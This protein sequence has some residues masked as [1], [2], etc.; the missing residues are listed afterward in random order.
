MTHESNCCPE[1]DNEITVGANGYCGACWTDRFGCE[2]LSPIS[3]YSDE[4]CYINSVI[5]IQTWWRSLKTDLKQSTS[6]EVKDTMIDYIS[7]GYNSDE[8]EM[9]EDAYQAI[10]KTNMWDYMKQEPRGGGGYMYTDDEELRLVN[11]HLEYIGHS[12]TSFAWTMRTMQLLARLGEKDFVQQ[13][14]KAFNLDEGFVKK[15]RE[16]GVEQCDTRLNT[17]GKPLHP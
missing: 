5:Q 17:D 12:G 4:D 13:C 1:C 9:L 10:E 11:R 2:D 7:L 16:S 6:L 14:R 3:H 8:H 15:D